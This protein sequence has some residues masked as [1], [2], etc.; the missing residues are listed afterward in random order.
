MTGPAGIQAIAINDC[1]DLLE[2]HIGVQSRRVKSNNRMTGEA[3]GQAPALAV[4]SM[5]FLREPHSRWAA[6]ASRKDDVFF[7][8]V[9][10]AAGLKHEYGEAKYQE[11]DP[12]ALNSGHTI[13]HTIPKIVEKKSGW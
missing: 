5:V 13:I 2:I 8:V 3:V 11:P 6:R 7:N 4:I 1:P 12:K 10:I 9:H